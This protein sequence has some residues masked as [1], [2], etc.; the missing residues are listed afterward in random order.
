MRRTRRPIGIPAA[1]TVF[2][3]TAAACGGGG[4]SGAMHESTKTTK[5]GAAM[6]ETTTTT[7][8]SA[9]HENGS[10]A[11]RLA[12]AMSGD[13]V[14]AADQA[15]D[16]SKLVVEDVGLT[17]HNGFVVVVADNGGAM[18][19]TLGVSPLLKA[20]TTMGVT[21]PLT[22]PLTKSGMVFVVL[23]VDNGDGVYSIADEPA[24]QSGT[25]VEL[26]VQLTVK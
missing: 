4:G 20:G 3:L 7:S 16:G 1:L 19:D 26:P 15:S 8:G 10:S 14:K 25:P 12:G 11:A 9:M 6:H 24:M 2:A 21:V 23:H 17:G 22:K 13:Y 18:G 5:S